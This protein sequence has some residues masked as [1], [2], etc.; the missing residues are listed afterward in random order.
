MICKNCGNNNADNVKFCSVCGTKMEAQPESVS[1]PVAVQSELS[2]KWYKCVISDGLLGGILLIIGGIALPILPFIF[3]DYAERYADVFPMLIFAV[4]GFSALA[5]TTGIFALIAWYFLKNFKRY[6]LML[7]NIT[8]SLCAVAVCC[9]GVYFRLVTVK[10]VFPLYVELVPFILIGF[11]VVFF[12][13][14]IT[15]NSIYFNK[16]KHLFVN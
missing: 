16:R 12:P 2:M 14:F 10:F 8:Y 6:S 13:V 1:A 5:L 4:F 9:L 7:L 3:P 11:A 15:L